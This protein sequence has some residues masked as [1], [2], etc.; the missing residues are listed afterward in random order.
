MPTK[1]ATCMYCGASLDGAAP[2][3]DTRITADDN[4]VIVSEEQTNIA[5]N[6]LSEIER[7]AILDAMQKGVNHTVIESKTQILQDPPARQAEGL[8]L[9]SFEEVNLQTRIDDFIISNLGCRYLNAGRADVYTAPL[10]SIGDAL[11]KS[12]NSQT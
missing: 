12:Q 5:L 10:D 3:F 4:N 8:S 11:V 9:K 1:K 2:N 6:D 7:Q